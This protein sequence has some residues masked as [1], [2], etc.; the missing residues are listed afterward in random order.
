MYELVTAGM[1]ASEVIVAATK[2]GAICLGIE[3]QTGTVVENKLADILI[4]TE[5]PI[6]NI[7]NVCHDNIHL[8]MK[9]G[10]IVDFNN[11]SPKDI[12]TINA[13]REREG[14]PPIK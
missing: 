6:E 8:I 1:T 13:K 4:L 5:N 3:D 11:M 2:N 14:K 12:I 9:Q 7:R 10:T